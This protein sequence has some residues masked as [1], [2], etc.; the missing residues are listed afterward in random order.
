MEKRV[1][2]R[3]EARK[4]SFIIH[5]TDKTSFCFS[6][7]EVEGRSAY[8]KFAV[9]RFSGKIIWSSADHIT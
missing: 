9:A 7:E 3:V 1:V 8:T 4:N 5:F 2:E 6:Y